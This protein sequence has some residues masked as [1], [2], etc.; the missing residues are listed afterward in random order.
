MT[1]LT[2]PLQAAIDASREGD[3][4]SAIRLLTQARADDPSSALTHYLLG[5]ELAECGIRDA[6]HRGEDDG[7]PDAHLSPSRGTEHQRRRERHGGGPL[8]VGT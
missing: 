2:P 8:V 5:A 6:R 7:W 3:T 4:R 1:T